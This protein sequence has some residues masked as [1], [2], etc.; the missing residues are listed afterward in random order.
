M[1]DP[2][3][4]RVAIEIRRQMLAVLRLR[5]VGQRPTQC[6]SSNHFDAHTGRTFA[7]MHIA[8]EIRSL[9]PMLRDGYVDELWVHE[10]AITANSHEIFIT[11]RLGTGQRASSYIIKIAAEDSRTEIASE[12]GDR[13]IVRPVRSRDYHI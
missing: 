5:G 10:R 8:G 11:A 1:A 7:R 2:K 4:L 6:R 3:T 9:N 12:R 13:I